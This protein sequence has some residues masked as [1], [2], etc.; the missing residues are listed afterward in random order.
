LERSE[1]FEDG[2][3]PGRQI[4][5]RPNSALQRESRLVTPEVAGSSRVAPSLE[6]PANGARSAAITVRQNGDLEPLWKRLR[7]SVHRAYLA[8]RLQGERNWAA[9]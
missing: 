9:S 3:S 5:R 4:A 7:R 1:D 2:T 8:A 6:V